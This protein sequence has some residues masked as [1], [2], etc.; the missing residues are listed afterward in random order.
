M[1][2]L[3]GEGRKREGEIASGVK[4]KDL[5]ASDFGTTLGESQTPVSSHLPRLKDGF[6]PVWAGGWG[7]TSDHEMFVDYNM[8]GENLD[9]DDRA[10]L[11][12]LSQID[13]TESHGCNIRFRWNPKI[14]KW[15][16]GGLTKKLAKILVSQIKGAKS[17]NNNEE[18]FVVAPDL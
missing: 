13:P 8:Q 11:E 1:T 7:Q 4:F 9:E 6:A 12:R 18:I 16:V 14:H 17:I 15:G 10:A 3:S 2:K 5:Q